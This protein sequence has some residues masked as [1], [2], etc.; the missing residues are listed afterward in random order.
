MPYLELLYSRKKLN[1]K[2]HFKCQK[3]Q[4]ADTPKAAHRKTQ[5]V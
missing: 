4:H 1:S 2:H 3:T 5:I